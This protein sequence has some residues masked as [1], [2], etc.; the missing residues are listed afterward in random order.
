MYCCV[1]LKPVYQVFLLSTSSCGCTVAW[2]FIRL[3]YPLVAKT[4]SMNQCDWCC[5]CLTD[6]NNRH[7]E[8][9]VTRQMR[10]TAACRFSSRWSVFCKRTRSRLNTQIHFQL[11]NKCSF[12]RYQSSFIWFDILCYSS[13]HCSNK[14]FRFDR[15]IV[16]NR[17]WRL[18]RDQGQVNGIASSVLL[19]GES[20]KNYLK[21][22]RS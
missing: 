12:H 13:L 21:R 17:S 20:S 16:L 7:T 11:P 4:Q 8:R 1:S 5:D 2:L 6:G 19:P 15:N 14:I 22:E 9:D 18:E 3:F 10:L